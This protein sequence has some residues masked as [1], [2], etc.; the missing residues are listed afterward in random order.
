MKATRSCLCCCY[1]ELHALI[2]DWLLMPENKSRGPIKSDCEC[3]F[4][5]MNFILLYLSYLYIYICSIKYI[6]IYIYFYFYFF[7][8]III[9]LHYFVFLVF[10]VE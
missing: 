7:I 3:M 10:L 2:V 4:C 5:M 9:F 8:I 1:V 6:N